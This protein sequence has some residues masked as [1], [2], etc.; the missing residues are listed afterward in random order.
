MTEGKR[1][2]IAAAVR[3]IH[4]AELATFRAEIEPELEKRVESSRT[5]ERFLAFIDPYNKKQMR[6]FK[7]D[8]EF[9]AV[10]IRWMGK[11][12]IAAVS[13]FDNATVTPLGHVTEGDLRHVVARFVFTDKN[14]E[15]I[16]ETVSVTSMKMDSGQPMLLLLPELKQV[17]NMVRELGR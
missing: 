8:Q 15:K 4:S 6:A 7:D 13:T 2:E 3:F 17:A 1:A 9:V 10:F 11:S 12:G 16:G 5:R 14:D